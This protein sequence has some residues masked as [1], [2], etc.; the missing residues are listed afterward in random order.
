MLLQLSIK[1]NEADE[2]GL[3]PLDIALSTGQTDLAR[4]LIEHNVNVNQ[5]DANGA[6]I[7]HNAIVRGKE[8]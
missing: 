4:T 7:I 2:K 8:T 6:T 1:L 3:L 5:V